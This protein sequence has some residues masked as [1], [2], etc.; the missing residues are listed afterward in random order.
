MSSIYSKIT[1]KTTPQSEQAKKTQVKN[2]AGGWTFKVAPLKQLERFL[3]LGSEGGTYYV[4]E[5]PLTLDNL[6]SLTA[7]IEEDYRAAIDLIADVSDKGRAYKND[8]AIFALACAASFSC[9]AIGKQTIIRQYALSKLS[10]VCRIPTHLFHFIQFVRQFRGTGRSLR[11]AVSAWYKDFDPGKLA[12]EL[13]KYQSRDGMSNRDV[14]RLMHPAIDSPAIRWAVGGADSAL[15]ERRVVRRLKTWTK[16]APFERTDVYQ[17]H[18]KLPEIIEGLEK[19]KVA[20]SPGELIGLITKYGLTHEMIPT[21]FRPLPEVQE[22]LLQGMPLHA[23]VRNL[24]NMSKSGLIKPYSVA[25]KLITGRLGDALYIHKSRLHPMALLIAQKV[26]AQGHGMRGKSTWTVNPSI[27]DALDAAFYL[28]FANAAPTNKRL[29]YAL[30]VSGSMSSPISADIPLTCAEATAALTLLALNTET[31]APYIMGFSDKFRDLPFSKRMRLDDAAKVTRHLTF[32]STDVAVPF[33][34]A[35]KQSIALDGIV[36]LTD[37]E[38][39]SGGTH[40]FQALTKYR[41]ALSCPA[42][43]VVVGMTST[44]FT[45]AD[46][47]DLLSLDVV[48]FDASAPPVI[49]SF[50]RGEL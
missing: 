10:L 20:T 34:W 30:D 45:I 49:N 39:W 47:S 8:P 48:G 41:Q 36:V 32:G 44:G 21:D 9:D 35:H 15:K 3:I 2:S 17:A 11:S 31:T 46:P 13:A 22:A 4:G 38:T 26:Y 18:E 14:L 6:K 33:I 50:L 24:G 42:R 27:V 43:Q 25:M 16:E 1:S 12:Y 40:P 5:K 7:A 19:A 23:M 28:A 29:L 37:N